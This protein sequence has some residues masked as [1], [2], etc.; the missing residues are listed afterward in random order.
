MEVDSLVDENNAI[1]DPVEED[2]VINESKQQSGNDREKLKVK[3]YDEGEHT[4]NDIKQDR[5]TRG[6]KRSSRM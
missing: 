3:F 1:A 2:T 6:R 5:K 4:I